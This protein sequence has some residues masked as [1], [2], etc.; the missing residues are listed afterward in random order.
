MSQQ[1]ER[2]R[3]AVIGAGITGLS[4]AY[5]LKVMLEQEG[6]QAHL[7]VFE[8]GSRAGGVIQTSKTL[9]GHVLEHGPDAFLSTK[10]WV[11]NLCRDLGIE[12]QIIETEQLNRRSLVACNGRLHALPDGFVMVAPGKLGTLIGS[13][14][15]SL[16]G[17]LRMALELVAPRRRLFQDETVESFILRRLGREALEKVAQ[18]MVGGIYV[19]DVSRLSASSTLPQFVE[20][21]ITEGSIIRGLLKRNRLNRPD[22]GTVSGA[23]YSMFVT[24]KNGVQT[25]VD[26]L[27]NALGNAAIRRQCAVT[28]LTRERQNWL[29]TTESGQERFDIVVCALPSHRLADIVRSC[30]PH[31]SGKLSDIEFASAAVVNLAFDRTAIPHPMNGFGFVVPARE[32][33]SILAASFASNKFANRAKNGSVTIRAFVGGALQAELLDMPNDRLVELVCRDLEYYLGVK[34]RPDFATVNR[35]PLSMPQY[36]LGH[37]DRV[38]YLMKRAQDSLPGVFLAGNSYN[39]VGLPDCVASAERAARQAL[40]YVQT[41]N[42]VE[43]LSGK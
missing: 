9:S 29:L 40:D 6:R 33:R 28:R 43:S 32:G 5:R 22:G 42:A 38:D 3:V 4:A 27:E 7:R 10:P 31:L 15:F 41:L 14:L 30:D 37:S 24:L 23:R 18:P 16:A 2:L 26:A 20:S 8:S 34:S 19:G 13:P 21:E 25:L 12:D 35:F 17:K 39:G 36:N 1:S 11:V